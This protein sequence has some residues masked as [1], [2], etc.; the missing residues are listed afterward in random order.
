[1]SASAQPWLD[2][3]D[4]DEMPTVDLQQLTQAADLQR[5][6]DAKY[7]VPLERLPEL[8]TGL[9]H[10]LRVLEVDGR[11]STD[12][13]SVYFDT[14]NLRSYHDHLKRR[15]RRFKVRTRH[16][17][18]EAG[19]ML[20]VK[21]KGRQERTVKHRWP[22][23]GPSPSSLGAEAEQRVAQ[24]LWDQYGFHLPE[25]LEPTA[26]TRFERFT[27]VDIEAVERITVDLGLVIEANG[28][29]V[30]LGDNQAIVEVKAALRRGRA[31]RAIGELGLRPRSMSKYC[32]GLMAVDERV[33]GNPWIPT[34]RR[35]VREC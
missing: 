26:I 27:L 20:E 10:D 30:Q 21:C 1:M 18:D 35:L 8:L 31:T 9:G 15:R 34:L 7:L 12:Y 33:R 14:A 23:T 24:T 17:G 11:R 25:A 3:L 2:R 5:R 22:H 4:L 19:T 16:Y 28:R 29:Q 13:T 32:V 6:F